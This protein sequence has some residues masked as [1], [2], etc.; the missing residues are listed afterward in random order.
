[1]ADR[2]F[3]DGNRQKDILVF[4]DVEENPF[5]P[6][7]GCGV[8]FFI[9]SMKR[10][11]GTGFHLTG[12]VVE[13]IHNVSELGATVK[14]RQGLPQGFHKATVTYDIAAKTGQI[15]IRD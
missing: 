10:L 2:F 13:P 3:Q 12:F 14:V 8:P 1:L 5:D 15:K 6:R 7:I 11:G 4:F 9:V